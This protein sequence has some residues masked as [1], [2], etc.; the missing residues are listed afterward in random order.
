MHAYI[1][2]CIYICRDIYI[3][4]KCIYIYVYVHVYIYT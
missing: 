1:Y 2:M 4:V 3:Y